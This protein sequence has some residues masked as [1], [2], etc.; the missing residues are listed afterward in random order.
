MPSY[1]GLPS[2]F[3]QSF[4]LYIPHSIMNFVFIGRKR[5]TI[6]IEKTLTDGKT[7]INLNLNNNLVLSFY[8]KYAQ[9]C[10][11]LLCERSAFVKLNLM[12]TNILLKSSFPLQR[13]FLDML[14]FPV[15]QHFLMWFLLFRHQFIAGLLLVPILGSRY[16]QANLVKE[17]EVARG[18]QS[19]RKSLEEMD[20]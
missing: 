14:F 9:N 5:Q 11:F 15:F 13:L 10:L 6:E 4:L 17:D 12:C 16:Y 3:S 7:F 18:L 2:N 20:K 19:G 8:R 1:C